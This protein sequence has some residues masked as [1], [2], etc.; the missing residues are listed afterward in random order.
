[1]V[2]GS[3]ELAGA[4]PELSALQYMPCS[5]RS[6]VEL[7]SSMGSC[8]DQSAMVLVSRRI[9]FREHPPAL[10][11]LLAQCPIVAPFRIVT[12]CVLFLSCCSFVS[13]WFAPVCCFVWALEVV[14]PCDVLAWSI[15]YESKAIEH[16]ILYYVITC[17]IDSAPDCWVCDT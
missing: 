4:E 7:S 1:M 6:R 5:L 2:A 3:E 12:L 13:S 14:M 15:S 9:C 17:S 8:Y 10:S 11:P 16:V